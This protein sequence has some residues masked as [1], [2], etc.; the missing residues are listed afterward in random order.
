MAGHRF[1]AAV[2]ARQTKAESPALRALRRE[3]A[4]A[5]HG[6]VLEVGVGVGTNF[7][8]LPDGIEYIGIDPDPHMIRRAREAAR[9]GS[10]A[11]DVEQLDVQRLPFADNSFDSA[12]T[13][14][15]FCSVPD[16]A[17]GLREVRRVLKPGGSF[18][19][20]EHVRS[21]NRAYAAFQTVLLPLTRGVGGGCEH[22]RDTLGALREAGFSIEHRKARMMGLPLI[23]GTATKGKR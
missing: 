4:G 14:L 11:L 7:Q 12:F 8:Y 2:W 17:A 16:A 13:T 18:R 23:I 3:I 10:A 9:S 15:T 6:R 19:F 20:A 1:F 21:Q 22:T 5:V